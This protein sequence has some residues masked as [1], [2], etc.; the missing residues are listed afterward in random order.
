M[1]GEVGT[2]LC[3]VLYVRMN[4]MWQISTDR[5]VSIVVEPLY[6]HDV[7]ILTLWSEAPHYLTTLQN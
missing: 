7:S 5:A 1:S 4:R 3:Y 6:T 2:I